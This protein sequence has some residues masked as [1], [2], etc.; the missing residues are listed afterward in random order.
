MYFDRS[1]Y[2]TITQ[3]D[4]PALRALFGRMIQALA[5]SGFSGKDLDR[6]RMEFEAA[7]AETIPANEPVFLLRAKD[8]VAHLAVRAWAHQHQL[9]GG[10]DNV[11]ARA[12]EHAQRMEAWPVKKSADMPEGV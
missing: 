2:S 8:K 3:C 1:D 11:F 6:C 10:A 5:D 9:N 7:M 12:M 4:K